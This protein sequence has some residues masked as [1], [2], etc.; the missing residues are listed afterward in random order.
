MDH[1][2]LK[3]IGLTEGEIRVYLAL[4]DSGLTTTGIVIKQSNITGSKVYNILDRLIEKGLEESSSPDS[5]S[6]TSA[7]S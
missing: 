6:S 2:Q 7:N 4:L 5:C 3:A 1:S